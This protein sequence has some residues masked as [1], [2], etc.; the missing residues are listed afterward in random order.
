MCLCVA[1]VST[2]GKEK[3]EDGG[4]VG[5]PQLHSKFEDN[6][7][8][9]KAYIIYIIYCFICSKCFYAYTYAEN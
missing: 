7:V 8:S 6:T 1:R 4:V 9:D 5:Q 3:Q 2:L